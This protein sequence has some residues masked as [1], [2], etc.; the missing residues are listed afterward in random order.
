[1]RLGWARGA[2]RQAAQGLGYEKVFNLGGFKDWAEA[3]GKV[4][5]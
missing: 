1:L 4:E 3:G 2:R 5:K